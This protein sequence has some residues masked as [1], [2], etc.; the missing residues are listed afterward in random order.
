MEETLA[1][2]EKLRTLQSEVRALKKEVEPV[3]ADNGEL[4]R[5]NRAV[6]ARLAK[7]EAENAVLEQENT[8]MIEQMEGM[9]NTLMELSVLF[10]TKFTHMQGKIDTLTRAASGPNVGQPTLWDVPPTRDTLSPGS[11]SEP[12]VRD[13]DSRII[14]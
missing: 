10:L 8:A 1:V 4:G 13:I 11:V 7:V 14:R 2:K 12:R 6:E 3:V 5:Q 9:N